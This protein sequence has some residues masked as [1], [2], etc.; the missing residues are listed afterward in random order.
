MADFFALRAQQ[1]WGKGRKV[2]TV[3]YN[4]HFRP[5]DISI[6]RLPSFASWN[7]EGPSTPTTLPW[8]V[9]HQNLEE[10]TCRGH[11]GVSV[12][13]EVQFVGV[14]CE[15]EGRNVKERVEFGG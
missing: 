12:S 7:S 14:G 9:S 8:L 10:M 1:A 15:L 11:I 4:Q 13:E 2:K 6:G 3:H 5:M